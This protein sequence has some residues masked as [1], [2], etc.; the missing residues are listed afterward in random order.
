MVFCNSYILKDI[1][2]L[3]DWKVIQ[4]L[5]CKICCNELF[6]YSQQC[7]I[8]SFIQFLPFSSTAGETLPQRGHFFPDK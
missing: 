7:D 6:P 2:F 5:Q 4:F 8:I 1:L 3:D